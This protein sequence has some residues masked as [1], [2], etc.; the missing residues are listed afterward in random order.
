MPQPNKLNA[1]FSLFDALFAKKHLRLQVRW[2]KEYVDY[3]ESN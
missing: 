1:G 3:I 2:H